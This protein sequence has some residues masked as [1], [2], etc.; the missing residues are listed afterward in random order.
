[1]KKSLQEHVQE[2]TQIIANV[3]VSDGHCLGNKFCCMYT[4]FFF[5]DADSFR[6]KVIIPV[7]S[8]YQ[9]YTSIASTEF[10]I[11]FKMYSTMSFVDYKNLYYY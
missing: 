3:V 1:M 9:K 7:D 8:N 5:K 4:Q 10:V 2:T 6:L 11:I